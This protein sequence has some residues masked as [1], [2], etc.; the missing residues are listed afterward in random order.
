MNHLRFV[1]GL[2]LVAW[3]LLLSAVAE[4]AD[5]PEFRAAKRNLS[6]QI[7]V[8]HVPTRVEA[9]R[10]LAGEPSVDNARL[11]WKWPSRAL[12][13]CEDWAVEHCSATRTMC[14]SAII[15]IPCWKTASLRPRAKAGRIQL[16]RYCGPGVVAAVSSKSSQQ[17]DKSLELLDRAVDASGEAVKWAGFVADQL[18]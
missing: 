11:C 9:V 6:K 16:R 13:R 15:C 5:T 4:A 8:K 14:R 1:H 7:S 17:V 10:K 3:V 18:V 12:R 2:V